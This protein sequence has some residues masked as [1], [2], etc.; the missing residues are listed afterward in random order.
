MKQYDVV[1]IGA[2][3]GGLKAALVAKQRGA[4]VA[5]LEKNKIGGDCTHYG[6]IPSKTFINSARL[7]HE[8]KH[9]HDLGLPHV[10]VE[11]GFDFADV[12][13]HVN[14]V[15]DDIY[16]NEWPL[17]FK[18]SGVDVVVHESGARFLNA[19]EIEIGGETLHTEHAI[20]CTGSSP[21]MAE[22]K[23]S[24]ELIFLNN[25]NFW[26]KREMPHGIVFLGGGV[27][28][29]EL[30]QA[31][32][33]FGCHVSIID[34]NPRILSV[35]DEDVGALIT[36]IFKREGMHLYMNAEIDVC[37]ALEDGRTQ[38]YIGQEDGSKTITARALFV[39]LG[40]APNVAGLGL[41][42]AGVEYD[43]GHGIQ[44]NEYL[45]TTAENIYA[46]GDVATKAKFTHVAGYQAGVCVENIMGGNHVVNDLSVLPWAIFTSPEIAHVGL[47]EAQAREEL[48]DVQVIKVDATIDRFITEGKT[49]GFLKVVLDKKD[50]IVGADAIGA[51]AGEWIQLITLAIKQNL[52]PKDFS[53]TIVAY[54]THADIVRKAFNNFLATK[55]AS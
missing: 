32:T 19:H 39:A 26:E 16:L 21:R 17:I 22:K 2:G 36:D 51:Q 29:A 13:E 12:M 41:E 40:R 10:D 53:E 6:C 49:E 30:G 24:H 25:E 50:R 42:E 37:E 48:G 5:L 9:T 52:T 55:I 54:P 18:D 44:T 35:V 27:I 3:A 47:N 28:S 11:G 38:I 46:C 1:V 14:E 33:R 8:M 23:G 7:F 31:L 4:K 43:D 20:V 45:Q 34:R 15:V